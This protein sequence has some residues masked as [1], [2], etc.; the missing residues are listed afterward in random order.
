[1]SQKQQKQQKAGK[2]Q[3]EEKHEEKKEQEHENKQQGGDASTY[4]T[5][6]YGSTDAQHAAPG[7]GNT[8]AAN[9]VTCSSGGSKK[10]KTCKQGGKKQQKQQQDGG[11]LLQDLAVPALLLYANQ[12]SNKIFG[13]SRTAHKKRGSMKRKTQRRR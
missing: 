1:M 11:S 9:Q 3:Q 10:K 13:H 6:V 5:A 8:I 7:M 4:A 2:K 12:Y